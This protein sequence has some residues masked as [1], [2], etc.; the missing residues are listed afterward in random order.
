MLPILLMA[1]ASPPQTADAVYVAYR[2]A[3]R[4]EIPCRQTEASDEIVVCALRAA[5]EYR[6]SFLTVA[7]GDPRHEGVFDE[8]TRYFNRTTPC[9][10]MGPFLIGCGSVGVSMTA[11]AD[12]VSFETRRQLAP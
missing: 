1:A 8:R 12:G 4:A 11:G 7:P 9:Q 6:I 2:E 10:D 5:D 3:T